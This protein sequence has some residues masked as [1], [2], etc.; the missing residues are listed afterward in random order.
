[1]ALF[2]FAI[3]FTNGATDY[4]LVS[5]GTETGAEADVLLFCLSSDAKVETIVPYD[6]ATI[7][8]EMYDGCAILTNT[9][10]GS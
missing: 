7:V 1:M 2:G 6:A 10:G 9:L 8:E 4:A 3:N 5:S